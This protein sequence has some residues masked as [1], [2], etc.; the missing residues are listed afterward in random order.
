[1]FAKVTFKHSF[2]GP[3]INARG[4]KKGS[5]R[6]MGAKK[7]C[8]EAS[9]YEKSSEFRAF[10]MV[11]VVITDSMAVDDHIPYSTPRAAK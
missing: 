6:E 1:M 8:Q 9:K 4:V 2:F 7:V 3:P 10:S 11:R 5:K